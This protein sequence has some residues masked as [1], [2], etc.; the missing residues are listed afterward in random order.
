MNLVAAGLSSSAFNRVW[1]IAFSQNDLLERWNICLAGV[2]RNRRH[3]VFAIDIN[4]LHSAFRKQRLFD[5]SLATFAGHSF[6]PDAPGFE[7][8]RPTL[9]RQLENTFEHNCVCLQSRIGA[10]R[11]QLSW[12]EQDFCCS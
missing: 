8:F 12:S 6:D 5:R 9:P 3:P 2:E 11:N 10:L 7:S 1:K 4:L